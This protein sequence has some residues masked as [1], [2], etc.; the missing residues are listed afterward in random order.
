MEMKAKCHDPKRRRGVWFSL[1][2]LAAGTGWLIVRQH[3]RTQMGRW[4]SH[5]Q[6]FPERTALVTGA[7]SGIGRAYALRLAAD[8]YNLVL[9]ARRMERLEALA[10]ECRTRFAVRAE[11]LP[12]DLSTEEGMARVEQRIGA[13]DIDFLVNNAGYDVFGDFVEIPIE[14]NLALINCLELATVRLT[15]AVL[16]GMLQRRFGAVVNVISIGAFTPKRKDVIYCASKA[17]D[18]S[19]TESLAL[20]L[21]DSGVRVQALCPG[22]TLSEFHDAPQYAVYRIKESVPSWLWQTPEA[23]VDA[24]F[25]TLGENRLL[26]IPGWKNQMIVTAARLGLSQPLMRI[27]ASLFP[28]ARSTWMPPESDWSMLVCP[29]CH[30]SLILEGTQSAGTLTCSECGRIYPVVDDIPRFAGYETLQGMNRRFAGLY[31]WFS[32]IYGLFSKAAFSFIGTTEDEARTEILD[33]L[34]PHGRVLE[35]SIGPGVNLPYLREYPAV[36][37]IYGMDISNGQ[38]AHCRS[39]VRRHRWQVGLVQGNAEALPYQDN[40]FDSVLHI[41]GI[42]FFDDKQKAID[43]MIRV[44][45]PGAKIVICDETERGARGYEGTLPGFKS[46][47]HGEREAVKPPVDLVPPQMEDVKLDET[48]WKGWFYA[49]EFRKPGSR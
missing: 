34:E 42:N 11:P 21:K 12:A 2:A 41:G 37:E 30:G 6:R 26:C 3:R 17:F 47:F 35:V 5:E 45:R 20:E 46:S 36:R 29:D 1:A 23:V 22:L 8:G 33:R 10:E 48:V 19:F 13:G 38:L 24:S 40:S 16:P 44:A 28:S 9:V 25:Q 27:F 49:L 4:K 31:D 14:K 18:N 7:S 39:L 32:I 43:E 15:R